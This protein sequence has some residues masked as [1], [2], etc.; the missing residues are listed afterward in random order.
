MSSVIDRQGDRSVV[1]FIAAGCFIVLL[2][3]IAAMTWGK[4]P[5]W[6]ESIFSAIAGGLVVKIADCLSA[7]VALSSGRQVE[8]MGDQLTSSIPQTQR[9]GDMAQLPENDPA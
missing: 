8:R 1:K 3:I 4:L 9:A 5:D 6:A 7:L 2:A